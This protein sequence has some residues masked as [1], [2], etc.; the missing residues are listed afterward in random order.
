VPQIR[1]SLSERLALS[2]RAIRS[3]GHKA[4]NLKTFQSLSYGDM[5]RVRGYLVR[6]EAPSDPRMAAAAVELAERY[7]RQSRISAVL[8]R[9]GP[10][11]GTVYFGA[12]TILGAIEGDALQAIVYA[13]IALAALRVS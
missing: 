7:Q 12:V 4:K 3:V 6:G 13:C 10:A 5:W 1:A 2:I 9:W 8:T 11:A